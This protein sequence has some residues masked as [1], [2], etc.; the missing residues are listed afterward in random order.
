MK[1]L[2]RSLAAIA[3]L[4]VLLIIAVLSLP[5][6]VDPNRFKGPL[7]NIAAR[8]NILL[9]LE[10]PIDWQ[11]FPELGLSLEGVS[12]AALDAPDQ[13]L[14]RAGAG[15]AAVALMPL[16][17]GQVQVDQLI[18]KD[19]AV[20]LVVDEQGRGN[21]EALSQGSEPAEE[22]TPAE[23]DTG[24]QDLQLSVERIA[25]EN[26]SLNYQDR[27]TG[28][29]F[30]LDSLFVELTDVNLDERAFPLSVEAQVRASE[31][32]NPVDLQLASQ[33]QA[34]GALD[35]FNLQDGQLV[36]SVAGEE[37]ARLALALNASANLEDA[38][39]YTAN[40]E[41]EPFDARALLTALGQELPAMADPSA[42]T[43]VG[44]AAQV[45]GDES[46][47]QGRELTLVLDETRLSGDFALALPEGGLPTAQLRLRGNRIDVDR[48][49]PPET[50]DNEAAPQDNTSSASTATTD[51]TGP[52]PLPWDSLRGFNADLELSMDEIVV[53]AMPVT[54][55]RLTVRGRDGMWNLS[56]LAAN[57]YEGTLQ[58]SGSLDARAARGD[59]AA[60]QFAAQLEGLAVQPLL[61]D[62]AEFEDLSG[63]VS[64]RLETQTEAATDEELMQNLEA[65]FTF[66]SPVLTFQGF[67]AEYF[68]CQAATQLGDGD[69]PATEWP[70]RTRISEVEGRL[71]VA[72]S[73]LTIDT[74][75][76]N[77][78]NLVLTST[79][80][81]DL[82]AMDYRIRMPMRL[83]QERTSPS[84]CLVESNFLRNRELDV[85]GCA[86][87]LDTMDFGEQCG[88]DTQAVADLAKDAV[89]YNLEK[90][91]TEKKEEVRETLRE[92][93]RERLGGDEDEESSSNLLKDLLRR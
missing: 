3:V 80:Y 72:D 27:Q 57:F 52:E 47:V 8:Q 46:N 44:L 19:L 74:L 14:G 25:L 45:E 39:A 24:S 71:S 26:A 12:I 67:N 78:E 61:R 59:R 23:E 30:A 89:R 86:G 34:N 5:F 2:K 28:Q 1:W 66:T 13:P 42:L 87:S 64:G 70:R 37:D 11:F 31:L 62:F 69:M 83:P 4:L 63:N 40:I 93:L 81:L 55:A 17:S 32:P 56:E 22:P 29:S 51:A 9:R 92:K 33:L 54:Q 88:L 60:L 7:E 84:G 20:D 73:R 85:L 76:A 75:N 43:A 79:G 36:L 90:R 77:V 10:G 50:D 35:R 18:L 49:L 16:F 91:T 82:E 41:L 48:Y 58:S 15:T 6:V 38:L 21:W 53:M 65:M 68:Y